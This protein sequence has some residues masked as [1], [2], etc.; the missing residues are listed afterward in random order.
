MNLDSSFSREIARRK[1]CL[2]NWLKEN[3]F[4][5]A[6]FLKEEIEA[7]NGNF[8]YYGGAKTS[9]EYSA[10]MIDSN[11]SSYAIAHEYSYERVATSGMYDSVYEIRQSLDELI[12]KLKQIIQQRKPRHIAVDYSSVR[13]EALR[14]MNE[15]GIAT[16]ENSLMNFVYSERS[17]KSPYE[18]KEMESAISVA[19]RAFEATIES[20]KEGLNTEGISKLLNLN[21]VEFGAINPSFE[22]D[23]R[24]RRGL[25]EKEIQRL[26]R[27]DLVLFDFGARLPSMYLSDVGRTIPFGT[28][29]GD[30]KDFLSEVVQIKKE[31]VKSIKRGKSGNQVRADID[32]I[33]ES[34]GYVSTHRP[35]HQIGINVHEPYEPHL[36]YGKENASKLKEGN[37]VTWEPGIGIKKNSMPKNRFGMAH[38]E[39]MV[40][41]GP[42]SKALGD[43]RLDYW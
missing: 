26:K 42:N 17:L 38:M 20:L 32:R 37:V 19:R 7:F 9:S 43:F 39:D 15:I 36:A 1:R 8:V 24:I 35:G 6:V 40:L 28:P 4:G 10:I 2:T 25:D 31:G 34:Q 23:I 21:L 27:G 41:V 3:N 5:A 18:I 13:S 14:K 16:P 12:S 33:I 11:E 22:T 30:I 29:S